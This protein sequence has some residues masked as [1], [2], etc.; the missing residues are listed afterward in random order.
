MGEEILTLLHRVKETV[1]ICK[2]LHENAVPGILTNPLQDG[3]ISQVSSASLI[4]PQ[5]KKRK[6]EN[7]RDD[8]SSASDDSN[9]IEEIESENKNENKVEYEIKE[10]K[11]LLAS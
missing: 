9:D 7:V 6:I 2:Q 11:H 1:A 3:E 8:E 4:S 5:N 10:E